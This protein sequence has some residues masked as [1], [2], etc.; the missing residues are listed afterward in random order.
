MEGGLLASIP[1]RNQSSLWL[2]ELRE[3]RW[4]S[5]LLRCSWWR[6]RDF[7]S[8][9]IKFNKISL[10]KFQQ[11][12]QK[13]MG[14]CRLLHK[15]CG[16]SPAMPRT[17]QPNSTLRVHTIQNSYKAFPVHTPS[18]LRKHTQLFKTAWCILE[19]F[20]LRL[21]TFKAAL[22]ISAT[23]ARRWLTLTVPKL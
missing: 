7:M 19:A 21:S 6:G 14:V 11:M 1:T 10:I 4:I 12:A 23:R 18:R 15:E 20:Q 22:H 8:V 13:W 5:Q 9:S 16:C 2:V 3:V 17:H